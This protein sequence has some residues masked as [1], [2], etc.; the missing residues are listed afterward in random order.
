MSRTSTAGDEAAGVTIPGAR[1]PMHHAGAESLARRAVAATDAAHVAAEASAELVRDAGTAVALA[2]SG[3]TGSFAA[4]GDRLRV[5]FHEVEALTGDLAALS[6]DVSELAASTARVAIDGELLASF[7]VSPVTGMAAEAAVGAA[8][9]GLART[10]LE[11]SALAVATGAVA[12]SYAAADAWLTAAAG[13]LRTSAQAASSLT[14]A[15]AAFAGALAGTAAISAQSEVRAELGVAVATS[16]TV[17]DLATAAVAVPLLAA[18]G[19]AAVVNGFG[20]EA[21]RALATAFVDA[22]HAFGGAD[23]VINPFVQADLIRYGAV[24]AAGFDRALSL[25]DA[26]AASTGGVQAILGATGPLYD[27]ILAGLVTAG[28]AVGFFHD[29]DVT[30]RPAE[31]VDQG[32]LGDSASATWSALG[33]EG[34]TRFDTIEGRVLPT[35]WASMMAGLAQ[36]DELGGDERAIIRVFTVYDSNGAAVSHRVQIPSTASWN[37]VANAGGSPGDL[38][39]DMYSMSQGADAALANSVFEAMRQAG[40]ATGSGSPPVTVDGF[41]LGGITAAAIAADA[42]GFN[43]TEIHTAGAPIGRMNVDPA[44]GVFALEADQDIVAALDGRANPTRARWLTV[45]GPG[46]PLA[47]EGSAPAMLPGAVHSARR[48]AA[49]GAVSVELQHVGALDVPSGGSVTVV[50]FESRREPN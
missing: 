37:P 36:I 5:S 13:S 9:T 23:D 50:D 8:A 12:T 29:G 24:L 45:T 28:V 31:D 1:L 7:S 2:R 21:R 40:V 38:T 15:G 14:Q 43:V 3:I 44:I 46:V 47:S 19:A 32:L 49:M 4:G 17:A 6:R 26:V 41:S 11:A 22:N 25:D 39:A 16:D 48:Y 10:A 30:V 27:D 42:R 20:T 34:E 35:D 33:R 18:G